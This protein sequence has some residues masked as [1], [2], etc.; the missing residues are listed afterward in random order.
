MPSWPDDPSPTIIDNR[1]RVRRFDFS[2]APSPEQAIITYGSAQPIEL[3]LFE[4][5]KFY[6]GLFWSYLKIFSYI[7]LIKTA[8]KNSRANDS[9]RQQSITACL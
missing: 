4:E 5:A 6:T 3:W 1:R 9:R 7:Y 8:N 2:E